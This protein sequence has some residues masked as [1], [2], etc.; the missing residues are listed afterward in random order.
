[1]PDLQNAGGIELRENSFTP[2]SFTDWN[3]FKN[4]LT[5]EFSFELC[6]CQEKFAFVSLKIRAVEVKNSF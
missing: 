3:F 2:N 1:L 5:D 4:F 6:T